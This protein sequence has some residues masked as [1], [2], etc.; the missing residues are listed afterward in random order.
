[1]AKPNCQTLSSE[2]RLVLQGEKEQPVSSASSCRGGQGL[3]QGPTWVWV[4]WGVLDQ[5]F[6]MAPAHSHFI[7]VPHTGKPWRWGAA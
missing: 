7:S 5:R 6:G 1:M 2:Q 4:W 3:S